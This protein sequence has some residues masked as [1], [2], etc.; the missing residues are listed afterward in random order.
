MSLRPDVQGVGLGRAMLEHAIAWAQQH[1]EIERIHLSAMR[2]NHAALALYRSTGFTEEA[3]RA[4]GYR[5]P[6]GSY[7][8]EV[9]M[10]REVR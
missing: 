8:D 6:D 1:P 9:L 5:Q 2:D 4:Q 3:H 10:S 7:Q